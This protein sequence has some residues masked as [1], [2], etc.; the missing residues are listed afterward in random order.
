MRD[1]STVSKNGFGLVFEKFSFTIESV[2][3]SLRKRIKDDE[4]WIKIVSETLVGL[5]LYQLLQGFEHLRK[6][7][8]VHGSIS[9]KTL[10]VDKELRLVISDFDY[11]TKGKR[12][13]DS[14]SREDIAVAMKIVRGL[15]DVPSS[16]GELSASQLVS[17]YADLLFLI[18]EELADLSSTI[19]S[20]GTYIFNQYQAESRNEFRQCLTAQ[21][22]VDTALDPGISDCGAARGNLRLRVS[23]TAIDG[24]LTYERLRCTHNSK[25][26]F[27]DL[28][29]SFKKLKENREA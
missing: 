21:F 17:P 3:K 20:V 27:N 10:Q 9:P 23:S 18:D 4:K 11:A 25:T 1:R 8:I 13:V 2:E 29:K 24:R 5:L 28:W 15:T 12:H 16:K 14:R 22:I 26:D 19:V 7:A 6:Y